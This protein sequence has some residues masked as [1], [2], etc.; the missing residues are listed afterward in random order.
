[1]TYMRT[2]SL[3]LAHEALSAVRGVI[4]SRFGKKYLPDE[5]KVYYKKAKGAQE[6]H[7]A[8]RPTYMNKST[9]PGNANEKK[10]YELIWKRTLASQMSDAE[11]EKTT[12][13]I[14][15]ENSKHKFLAQG[16]MIK[17]DGFL[18]VYIESTDDEE[19][20][21]GKSLLPI[22]N[23]GQKLGY[24]SISATQKFTLNPPR[25]TE[26][27]LV[28]KLEE[29]GIGRPST[30]APTISTIQNRGYVIKED[31]AGKERGYL[32]FTLKDNK[33]TKADKTEVFGT[34]KSKLFP[35]DIGMVVNDYLL[36]HFPNILD[37]NFTAD[38]EKQFDDIAEG[39]M[40]W[41]KMIDEFY[42]PF[43]NRIEGA[44][45]IV[46]RK[47]GERNIGNDPKTGK[48]V[49]VKIGRYGPMAQI[50]DNEDDEKP[51]Y[52][53]LRR[54]QHIETITLEEAL[55]LFK[56]PRD[57]G[58][59]ETK[60]VVAAIGRFGPYVRHD[61]KF[62]SLKKGIDDP[63][64]VEL[65]RAI[66]LIQEKRVSDENKN[67]AVFQGTDGDIQILN[68]RFG[69]YIVYNKQN[70]RIPKGKEVKELTLDDCLEII[71]NS[72]EKPPR[73]K[74]K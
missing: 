49:I 55:E 22:I 56:L 18:K 31:R 11:L 1:I 48:P 7:E 19:E 14:D 9:I 38:V 21:G 70:Y 42:H 69:P 17:F 54:D 25:Y 12:I 10:L 45:E 41:H 63:Y 61:N 60:K 26:A 28:R 68:G 36:E 39:D 4:E 5:P 74:G 27:S 51:Q 3:N 43:H 65:D 32:Q 58:L 57:L 62:Y 47:S 13:T 23:A 16:E 67:I 71:K 59:F 64:T 30:Y 50:G 29:L 53:A 66:E 46:G 35:T 37:F 44:L 40:V 24:Q 20:D 8:I 15:I 73:K 33:I 6:A 34:E 2:D 52:A 72:P